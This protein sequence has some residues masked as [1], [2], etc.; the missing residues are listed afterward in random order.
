LVIV[1][2]ITAM[3]ALAAIPR[4]I[5]PLPLYDGTERIDVDEYGAPVMADWNGDGNKDLICGQFDSGRI[6][7]YANLGPDSAPVFDG[8]T[9]LRADG[10]EITLPSV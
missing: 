6:R 1:L 7:F 10:A 8:Y 4:F 3:V 2:A 9:F 5:G